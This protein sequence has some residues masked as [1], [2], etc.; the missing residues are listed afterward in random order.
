LALAVPLSRFTSRVGGGST[1]Y[2]R[3][4]MADHQNR[5]DTLLHHPLRVILASG[6]VIFSLAAFVFFGAPVMMIGA[7]LLIFRFIHSGRTT[8]AVIGWAFLILTVVAFCIDR[9]KIE[10]GFLG[11]CIVSG[12]PLLII[13]MSVHAHFCRGTDKPPVA[14]Q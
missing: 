14:S 9:Q 13:L 3:Y 5:M 12:A 4:K 6:G 7:W 1:F 10:R 2:V 11:D 8:L